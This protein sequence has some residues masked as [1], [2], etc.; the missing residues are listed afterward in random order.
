MQALI[1]RK[2]EQR[3]VELAAKYA[4]ARDE[5]YQRRT[6]QLHALHAE[7]ALHV[8]AEPRAVESKFDAHE[9]DPLAHHAS[10]IGVA[11]NTREHTMADVL[12]SRERLSELT[13]H[14]YADA[15]VNKAVMPA[16][17]VFVRGTPSISDILEIE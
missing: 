2:K 4:Q 16:E 14:M 11:V 13:A 17:L 15:V 3:S 10:S 6:H 5:H 8:D 9:D 1:E 12:E 7:H